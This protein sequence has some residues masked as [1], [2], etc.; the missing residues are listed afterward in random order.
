MTS[1]YCFSFL[2]SAQRSSAT[3]AAGRYQEGVQA[4]ARG[5][6]QNSDG[7]TGLA[8]A[9]ADAT[10]EHACVCVRALRPCA[11]VVQLIRITIE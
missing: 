9:I 7:R 3:T 1:M 2:S 4:R 6:F 11:A 8:Y 5:L 10:K